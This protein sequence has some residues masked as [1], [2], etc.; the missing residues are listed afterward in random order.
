MFCF[1]WQLTCRYKLCSACQ[2]TKPSSGETQQ[3]FDGGINCSRETMITNICE[4]SPNSKKKTCR[5]HSSFPVE[6]GNCVWL[7]YL[8]VFLNSL[9]GKYSACFCFTFF[10]PKKS[11]V[12]CW[13]LFGKL[14]LQLFRNNSLNGQKNPTD[15]NSFPPYWFRLQPRETKEKTQWQQWKQLQ[16][17]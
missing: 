16:R 3:R 7:I 15:F 17:L 11:F 9:I 4:L 1:S 10:P 5:F 2:S 12:R 13:G 14:T 6:V 8:F